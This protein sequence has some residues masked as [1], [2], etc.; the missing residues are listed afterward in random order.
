MKVVD[1]N[2]NKYSWPPKGYEVN[3]DD[4]RPRSELHLRCREL[5][6]KLYPT[7]P[8]LE[9][10]PIPGENLFCDFYLPRRNMVIECNGEQHYTFMRHFHGTYTSFAK[11]KARDERKL[12]WCNINN[13]KFIVLPYNENDEQWQKKIINE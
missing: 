10:V 4:I 12:Q 7:Q 1:F 11:H 8:I 5:L 2:G 13:I 3:F 9:E 6:R